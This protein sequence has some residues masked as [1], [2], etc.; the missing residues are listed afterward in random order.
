MP[1]E[2]LGADG[3]VYNLEVEGEHNYFVSGILVHNCHRCANS[4]HQTH[5]VLDLSQRAK[6]VLGLSGTPISNSLESIFYPALIIDGGKAL[7]PSRKAFV[8]KFFRQ[9]GV[10]GGFTKNVPLD[11]AV[12]QV[13]E[14]IA[15]FTYF[16]KKEEVLDLPPKTHTP[17]YLEM[18][19]EQERYYHQI[20]N[21]AVTYIQDA[22]VTVE[23]AAARMMK[24]MQICQGFALADDGS[25]RHFSDAKTAALADLL[26]NE[27][28]S[29]KVVVW[30]Y[31]NYEIE[32][33]TKM[34]MDRGIPHIRIDGTVT[35]QRARDDAMDRWNTDPNLRVY[36]RQLSMSEGVTLHAK[37]SQVPCYDCIY[38]ALSYRYVDWKQSQDRIHRIGQK[39]PCSYT[40]FLTAEGID[41]AVYNAVLAKDAVAGQVQNITKDYYLSL[42]NAKF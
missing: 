21:E 39:H 23:Q 33:L 42:L 19:D 5:Y 10:G 7:G 40:Y 3:V 14:R 16:V 12:R 38:L 27:L 41:R 4:T 34:L 37:D 6:R 1:P 30:G 24:L 26:A 35:S 28:S 20:K 15:E 22:S 9:I 36:I 29:R 25:G 11:D 18:T 13:S 2:V 32:R 31:F 17:V 8:E